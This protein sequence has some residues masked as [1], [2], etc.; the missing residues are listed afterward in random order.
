MTVTASPLPPSTTARLEHLVDQA[1]NADNGVPGVVVVAV[2]RHGQEIFSRA[3]GPR[4][5]GHSEPMSVDDV[6]WIASCTKMIVGIACM[7]LVERG[8]LSLDDSDQVERYCPEL[9]AVQVLQPDGTLVDKQR[10]ITLRMLLCHTAGF[11]YSFMHP[12]LLEHSQRTGF[13]EM[14]NSLEGFM[15]PLVH[16]PGEQWRYGI[17]ID[18][19]GVLLERATGQS[20]NDYLHEHIFQPLDLEN[21]S[22]I[23][24][25]AMKQRLVNMSARAPD[26]QLSAI[27]PIQPRA[28]TVGTETDGKPFFHSG[29]GG[30]FAA[31]RDYCQILAVLLNN[32]T[33]PT[34]KRQILRPE[35]VEQ[36]FENQ[37]AHLPPLREKEMITCKPHVC[38]AST[39]LYPSTPDDPQ[40]WGLS[41]M[42]SG[43]YTGR[44]RQTVS[45]SGVANLYWWCDRENGV[46]GMVSSQ[47]FPFGDL[48][49][50]ELWA[51]VEKE[52][53]QGLKGEAKI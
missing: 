9:K 15:Q 11:G 37:I 21:I 49:V 53:Y 30:G 34:T 52:I 29:G 41:F 16:Q 4:G 43:G 40:G 31:P 6:F 28:L 46:A 20:L 32:G 42:I 22:L 8:L 44:S 36:M 19:A 51:G 17:N 5:H 12:Q 25:E 27:D 38:P 47:V 14:S 45:W 18:W 50:F 39:G 13:D 10:G 24:T 3:S 23:P 33:S 2:D 26:G 35:T 48:K 7:Q 1:T